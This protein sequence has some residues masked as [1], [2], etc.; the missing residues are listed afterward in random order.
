MWQL[1][2]NI[3][4]QYNVFFHKAIQAL[5][6][7]DSQQSHTELPNKNTLYCLHNSAFANITVGPFG[8]SNTDPLYL[9]SQRML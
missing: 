3:S 4:R 6:A 8:R 1:A 2:E 5:V 9:Q 7:I